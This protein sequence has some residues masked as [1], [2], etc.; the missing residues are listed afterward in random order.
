MNSYA[1]NKYILVQNVTNYFF[2]YVGLKYKY[3]FL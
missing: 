1:K 3:V 2:I